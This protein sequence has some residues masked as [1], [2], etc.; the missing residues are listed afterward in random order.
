MFYFHLIIEPPDKKYH[1]HQYRLL[2]W[3]L[4][5]ISLVPFAIFIAIS[6]QW[7]WIPVYLLVD[8]GVI[9]TGDNIEEA[10][11]T[12][13]CMQSIGWILYSPVMF[14]LI[15]PGSWTYLPSWIVVILCYGCIVPKLATEKRILYICVNTVLLYLIHP[16]IPFLLPAWYL[17][18]TYETGMF[19]IR[20]VT[21]GTC[22]IYYNWF[23]LYYPLFP[24]S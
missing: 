8:I 20:I 21:L 10:R 1:P 24:S 11:Y 23:A 5:V 2:A 3:R 19:W 4:F 17:T 9:Y 22:M 13:S 18:Y 15:L 16:I 14:H 12:N 6:R 7:L